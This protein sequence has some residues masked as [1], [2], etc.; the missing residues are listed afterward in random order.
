LA[1]HQAFDAQE[2]AIRKQQATSIGAGAGV[3]ALIALVLGLTGTRRDEAASTESAPAGFSL[4]LSIEEGVVSHAKPLKGSPAAAATPAA[5]VPSSQPAAPA[6]QA[7][8]AAS[9]SPALQ[10]VQMRSTVVLKAAADLSTDFGRVRDSEELGRLLNRA[11]DMLDASGLIVWIAENDSLRPA[12]SHGYSPNMLARM[13]SM[14]R[15]ADNAA[16]AACRTGAL[17]IVLSKPGGPQGAIVAPILT[18]DGCAGAL[19][20]E[21]KDGGEGSEAVQAVATIVAAHLASV[22]AAAPAETTATEQPQQTRAA[23]A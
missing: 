16:A 12:L 8:P 4:G 15:T 17:Q 1:E 10:A 9:P 22:V 21:I 2:A 13:S 6:A 18:A 14:P 23:H 3:A 20:A 5:A 7:P 19:S 11:A